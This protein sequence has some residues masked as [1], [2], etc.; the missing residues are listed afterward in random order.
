MALSLGGDPRKLD[1]LAD[2]QP[3]D[4]TEASRHHR[5]IRQDQTLAARRMAR[6]LLEK[7]DVHPPSSWRFTRGETGRLGLLS[8]GGASNLDISLSHRDNWIVCAIALSG[9][10]GIDIETSRP[11]RE[12]KILAD[13]YF[14]HAERT[15]VKAMGEPAF[16]ACW[17]MREAVVKAT[18]DSL[19][20]ALALDGDLFLPAMAGA[21]AV[22]LNGSTWGVAHRDLDDA[23]LGLAWRPPSG[24]SLSDTEIVCEVLTACRNINST[25][26]RR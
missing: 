2:A 22:Q 17:T 20:E 26:D 23:Q 15:L 21:A 3:D 6:T 12:S 7:I 9:C 14:S 13:A 4:L 10:I 19:G 5:P 1:F 24:A 11:K 18:G 8:P 16:L 25:L